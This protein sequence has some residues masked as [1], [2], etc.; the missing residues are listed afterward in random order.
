ME[1]LPELD[2]A[3]HLRVQLK[4]HLIELLKEHLI[5]LY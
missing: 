1:L 5:G 4:E 3:T 2:G